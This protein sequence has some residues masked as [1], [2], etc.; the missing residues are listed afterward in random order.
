MFHNRFSQRTYRGMALILSLTLAFT[1][2]W[3]LSGIIT[4]VHASLLNPTSDL[5]ALAAPLAP[6]T[7][8][9]VTNANDD[10]PGSLRLAIA[11]AIDG[12]VINFDDNYSIYLSSTLNITKQLTIDGGVYTITVSGD[13][14]NDGSR[15]VRA[16][17]ITSTAV[18]T[19]SHLNIVSGTTST[20]NDLFFPGGGIYVN[21]GSQLTVQ[22]STLTSNVSGYVGGGGIYNGG[23]L[24]LANSIFADNL[25]I[26]GG[27]G[28]YNESTLNLV[29]S[30][31][32][33][34]ITLGNGGAIENQGV[35]AM[36]NTT[37]I[38]ND[39]SFIGGAGGIHNLGTLTMT[40]SMLMSNTAVSYGG[41]LFVDGEGRAVI[42]NSTLAG[43]SS[44]EGGGIENGSTLLIENTTLSNNTATSGGGGLYNRG[45]LTMTNSTFSGNVSQ[46]TDNTYEG[47]GAI[48][49][50]GG[51]PG[52]AP[53]LSLN[54]VT[55]A[56]NDAPYIDQRDGIWLETGSMIL[57]NVL[58]VHN[59]TASCT[60]EAA[61]TA[62]I[63]S[64]NMSN[65]TT[66]M[67][68]TS[69]P[70]MTLP[71]LAANDGRTQTHALVPGNPAIDAGD[72]TTCLPTDQ[73][74]VARPQGLHC[75]IGAYERAYET[76]LSN[77]FVYLPTLL[78]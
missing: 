19:L 27:G 42:Q 34:N 60:I 58:L 29:N 61:A 1:L 75:D 65:D 71:S 3:L 73:R 76:S 37:L 39:A 30:T 43:N 53:A 66:C 13:S 67:G 2:L 69:I 45:I 21:P 54:N 15:N 55:L 36:S 26:G 63:A 14:L 35:L 25:S 56:N 49:Q 70:T 17:F 28:I 52:I 48:D 77:W 31:L 12:D 6:N 74:G 18:V 44:R 7:I 51:L 47:G 72:D 24:T 64:D 9:T 16:F 4:P 11:D 22:S 46:G 8:L 5:S 62:T 40:N 78:R 59:G 23:M 41:G 10:G 20:V 32:A 50:W 68:A 38:S 57:R 33:A